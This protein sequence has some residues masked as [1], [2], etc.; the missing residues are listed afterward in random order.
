MPRYVGDAVDISNWVAPTRTRTL[1]DGEVVIEKLP[2][3][4]SMLMIDRAGH[5]RYIPM[6]NGSGR[7]LANDPYWNKKYPEKL[8]AGMLPYGKCPKAI[9]LH[10]KL[11]ASLQTDGTPCRIAA[12]GS[13]ISNMHPCKC[14]V[15][16]EAIRKRLNTAND[17]KQESRLKPR[18]ARDA[19]QRDELHRTFVEQMALLPKGQVVNRKKG[20][21]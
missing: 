12:D 8:D 17:A 19:E 21:E 13:P 6:H 3:S 10:E 5:V 9:G 14:I 16:I 20:D 7:P 4:Q 11:P 2:P 18:D 15:E 1:P